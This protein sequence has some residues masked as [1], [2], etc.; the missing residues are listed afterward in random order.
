MHTAPHEGQMAV[1]ESS[2][3]GGE[4]VRTE[5]DVSLSIRTILMVAGVVAMVWALASIASVLD[6]SRTRPF[7]GTRN[8]SEPSQGASTRRQSSAATTRVSRQV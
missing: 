4:R 5:L 6:G 7:Y 2:S 3:R 1:A 8:S